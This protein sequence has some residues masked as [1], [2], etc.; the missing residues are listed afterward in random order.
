MGKRTKELPRNRQFTPRTHTSWS[1]SRKCAEITCVW[2]EIYYKT[3]GGNGCIKFTNIDACNC[4]GT[5]E[6]LIDAG[7]DGIAD[8]NKI[9]DM[10]IAAGIHDGEKYL[11]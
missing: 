9:R 6:A 2:N 4:L 5:I 8:F 11:C 1:C 7:Y 3:S 10:Q